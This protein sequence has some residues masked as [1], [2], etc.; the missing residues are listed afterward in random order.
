MYVCLN[1]YLRNINLNKSFR[2]RHS[3]NPNPKLHSTLSVTT[4]SSMPTQSS[5]FFDSKVQNYFCPMIS[6]QC[7]AFLQRNFFK[8]TNFKYFFKINENAKIILYEKF[9]K[10]I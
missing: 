3:A 1:L 4:I 5:N 2:N 7:K 10:K 8:C 6:N 9:I